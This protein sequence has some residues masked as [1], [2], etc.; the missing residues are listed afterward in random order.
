MYQFSTFLKTG[1]WAFFTMLCSF[2]LWISYVYT[3]IPSLL[4][5]G[6]NPT[7]PISVSMVSSL[8]FMNVFVSS[9]FFW[10]ERDKERE[11][12]RERRKERERERESVCVGGGNRDIWA[13]IFVTGHKEAVIITC[14]QLANKTQNHCIKDSA[15]EGVTSCQLML[16]EKTLKE[17]IITE[18]LIRAFS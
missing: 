3:Y 4:G 8:L 17:L 16:S 15:F 18:L 7:S 1:T 2:L 5:L 6:P 12:K 9:C 14:K 10:R 11:R 13:T